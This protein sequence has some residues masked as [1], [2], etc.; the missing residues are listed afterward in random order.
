V[1]TKA[2]DDRQPQIDALEALGTRSDVDAQ[3]RRRIDQEIRMI[4]AG[5]SGERDAAYEIE[6]HL[7]ASRNNMTIH[8][9]RIELDGR[10]AQIDHLIINRLLDIWVCESKHFAEGVAIDQH[11]EWVAFFGNRPHGIP[12]PVEQ[13]RR[14]IDVLSDVFAKGVVP[15]PKRL[16]I[17]IRPQ[18]RSLVL[19]SNGARISR[20]KGKAAAGVDGLDSVIKV[21]KLWPTI[22]R[23]YNQHSA[24]AIGKLVGQET[25][26]TLAR[27]LIALHAPARV[28]WAAKFGL[29]VAPPPIRAFEVTS[30][31][32][33]PQPTPTPGS[34][35]TVAPVGPVTCASCGRRISQAVVTYCQA[36]AARF[37]GAI[38]SMDCQKGFGRA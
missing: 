16:G 22:E 36:H 9:L 24:A 35:P 38:Y 2:I 20:P 37:R 26:E 27:R 28:D 32:P 14:H 15:L 7:G 33:T 13:N 17:T 30:P 5:A 25:V 4:R 12:S 1:Q 19:V 11:G 6:F 31:R 34:P 18:V 21:E 10:V 23:A 8:D 3:T 29:P